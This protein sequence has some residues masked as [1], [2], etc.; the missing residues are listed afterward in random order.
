MPDQSGLETQ[1][2]AAIQA[3][4]EKLR[5]ELEETRFEL[6]EISILCEEYTGSPVQRVRE[7]VLNAKEVERDLQKQLKA[8]KK[9]T[10]TVPALA[11]CP[12][13]GTLVG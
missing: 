4:R 1:F 13:C 5:K 6:K 9:K 8:M 10:K 2:V 12:K 7:L 11:P 3:D